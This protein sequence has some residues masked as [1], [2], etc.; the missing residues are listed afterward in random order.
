MSDQHPIIE[1]ILKYRQLS[2]LCSTYLNAFKELLDDEDKIHTIFNQTLTSTGRLSSSEPNLQNIPVKTEEGKLIRKIFISRFKNGKIV[3]ADYNQIELRLLAV[4]SNDEELVKSY[5][6]DEDIHRRTASSIFNM[7]YQLVTDEYRKKAKAVNFGI[8]YGIS[9]FGLSKN[10]GT[11]REEAK[12]FIERY[13]LKYPRI[14]QYMNESVEY[15]KKHKYVKTYFG[16]IRNIPE[17]E[18]PKKLIRNFG[19]RAAMNMPLQ[20]TA[21]DIIKIA[22][23]R[24][25]NAIEKENL[26]SKL[27]LTIHD[28]LIVDTYPGEVEKIKY[29]LQN[30]MENI[31]NLNVKLKVE[32]AVGDS[33]YNV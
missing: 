32:I 8:V 17:L 4:F 3:S 11:T 10:T 18:D 27:I 20:G 21:S 7:P 6:N 9:D 29:I 26:K 28:E 30:E 31:V 15:A 12:N 23:V 19:E 2:K 13:Y 24:V 1:K 22:M 25:F 16:R 5:N 33:W 14:K